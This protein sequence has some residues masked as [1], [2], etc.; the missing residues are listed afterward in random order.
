MY[1]MDMDASR[2]VKQSISLLGSVQLAETF[3]GGGCIMEYHSG[4]QTL[5]RELLSSGRLWDI[6]SNTSIA[7]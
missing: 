3:G 5:P 6:D 2:A 4:I 7:N 1:S